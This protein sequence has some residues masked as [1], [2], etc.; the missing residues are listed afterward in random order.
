MSH[1]LLLGALVTLA[2]GL[3]QGCTGFGLGMVLSPCLMFLLPPAAVVPTVLT[4]SLANTFIVVMHGRRHLRL[5]LVGPLVATGLLG[6]RLGVEIVKELNPLYIKLSVGVLVILF[7]SA[8][9]AGWRRTV[10]N[11]RLGL[12]GVGFLGGI[13]GGS[14]SMSGPPVILFLSNQGIPRDTFRANISCFF[15]L[16]GLCGLVIFNIEGLYTLDVIKQAGV[17]MPALLLGSV[18]GVWLSQ[19]VPELLFQRLVMI[20]I[21][22]V[23]ALL[24]VSNL[25]ALLAGQGVS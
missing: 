6:M 12:L 17:Y 23:G 16:N 24:V 15:L 10:R 11:E 4:I 21:L 25:G 22:C 3:I 19:R 1:A 9:L 2:G 5:G 8:I 18:A 13:L 7:S 14:T 20:G